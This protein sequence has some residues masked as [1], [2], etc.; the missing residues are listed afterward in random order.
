MA[1]NVY[2][3]TSDPKIT[4]GGSYMSPGYYLRVKTNEPEFANMQKGGA[5]IGFRPFMYVLEK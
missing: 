2:E 3:F 5:F 4:K 1:G